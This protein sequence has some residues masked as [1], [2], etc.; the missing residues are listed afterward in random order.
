MLP[1]TRAVVDLFT[2]RSSDQCR[3][4]LQ[5]TL[6]DKLYQPAH[7]TAT[8]S[9]KLVTQKVGLFPL[10]K[11]SSDAGC[12][13]LHKKVPFSLLDDIIGQASLSAHN[14]G[15]SAKLLY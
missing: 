8:T 7:F 10:V 14:S 12:A 2:T 5:Q 3:Q 15:E 6:P 4:L 11:L 9:N 13:D 1:V